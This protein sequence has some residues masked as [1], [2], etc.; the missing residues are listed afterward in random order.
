[1]LR[2]EHR[3]RESQ[4]HDRQYRRAGAVM[5][6]TDHGKENLC[7]QHLEIAAENQRV[8]EVG[9][10]LDKA[11]QKRVG[12]ARPHQRQGYRLERS[13]AAGPQGLRRLL[14]AR[15]DTLD[16]ADQHQKGDRCEGEKLRQTYARPA[17]DPA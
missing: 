16:D 12:D 13:P 6:R 17:V 4:Q 9:E 8:A 14:E 10:A 2:I 15:A 5:R 3:Q 1:M 11:Q 7:R